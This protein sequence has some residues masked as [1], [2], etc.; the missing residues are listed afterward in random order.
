MVASLEQDLPSAAQMT[1]ITS[2]KTSV[3]LPKR[4]NVDQQDWAAKTV[5]TYF[6][7]QKNPGDLAFKASVIN[8]VELKENFYN[9]PCV[10][11]GNGFK[12]EN[13]QL[14]QNAS[15]VSRVILI[16][17]ADLAK[18]VIQK[19][20]DNPSIDDKTV[21]ENILKAIKDVGKEEFLKAM[22]IA[23]ASLKLN[24]ID[25]LAERRISSIVYDAMYALE[26]ADYQSRLNAERADFQTAIQ[27][28]N[29]DEK[30]EILKNKYTTFNNEMADLQNI[31]Y[32][33]PQIKLL[34]TK[35][36]KEFVIKTYVEDIMLPEL[37]A[38]HEGL[39]DSMFMFGFGRLLSEYNKLGAST[40]SDMD[41]NVIVG[42]VADFDISN[43]VVCDEKYVDAMTKAIELA[44]K[45][46]AQCDIE[47][48]NNPEFT[49]RSFEDFEDAIMLNGRESPAEARQKQLNTQ[50]Y[51]SIQ[52][53]YYTFYAPTKTNEHGETIEGTFLSRIETARDLSDQDPVRAIFDETLN[54]SGKYSIEII[55]GKT[56][57][58][59]RGLPI[60]KDINGNDIR[61][62]EVI[63]S[64]KERQDNW[65][66]S[67]KYTV[68]RFYDFLPKVNS[69]NDKH[70]KDKI[71]LADIGL[72][73]EDEL[74]IKNMNH[75]M[76]AL[77]NYA[78]E[79]HPAHCDYLS[80]ADF[81]ELYENQEKYPRFQREF[82]IIR[83]KF[84][85][86]FKEY[87]HIASNAALGVDIPE[88]IEDIT[89][90]LTS[91]LLAI[92][93]KELGFDFFKQVDTKMFAIY[94][95]IA[96]SRAIKD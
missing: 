50:F 30:L 13:I 14:V 17:A 73:Y 79:L 57:M 72:T 10:M 23:R 86:P 52:N 83:N 61:V 11:C 48:E 26:T 32:D 6:G 84:N 94:E 38:K 1:K 3:P 85:H 18:D 93:A 55:H 76:Q 90:K 9:H 46:L 41:S 56:I 28:K 22:N 20:R 64:G 91:R 33:E 19:L 44:Q 87:W 29:H 81:Q 36:L 45:E 40:S 96:N 4:M 68:N 51:L 24:I 5:D 62:S 78:A 53:E 31:T 80:A 35:L 42:S 71:S 27:G 74:F 47:L 59:N 95:K 43:A 69:Y 8:D 65:Y 66:F 67:M 60:D 82:K 63:G 7:E 34:H 89:D 88:K 12:P 16:K 75:L 77:Q 15:L 49:V 92:P 58:S 70:P 21:L 37:F 25:K 54:V 2:Q 39:E